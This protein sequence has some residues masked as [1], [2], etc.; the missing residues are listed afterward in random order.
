MSKFPKLLT[1]TAL[2]AVLATPAIA[3]KLGLGREA[4]PE[5]VAAWNHDIGPQGQGLPVGSGSVE[6][7]EMIFSDNCASCHGEFA[8]GAGNW[9]KLAGGEGSLA[10]KDPLKTV[11][12]YWPYLSTVYDY[13]RRSMPFGAAQTMSDN[14]VYA[15]TAYIL[16]S[17]YLVED[18][19]V[20][21]NEN[22]LDV[23]MPNAGGF[24][25]DDREAA[26]AHFWGE[27]CYEN[28]KESVEIT[29][30]AAVLDVTPQEE[31]G[32][33]VEAD[34]ATS[35]EMPA[36]VAEAAAEAEAP[37]EEAA[38]VV[39]AFDADL[40]AK[41]ENVF[42]KCKACHQVG[43]GAKNKTGPILNG[44]YMA[45]VAHIDGFKYSKDF[46]SAHDEGVIWDDAHLTEF[47]AKPKA[48]YKK[49]KM[50]FAGLKKDDD[51]VAVIEY[52]KSVSQ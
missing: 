14:D 32:D 49:T 9:P 22:F 10:D 52:L 15:I 1:A 20:L 47:L 6:D 45:P 33:T 28:C 36:Q 30:R 42:K 17:N 2:V 40:A 24:I 41:G 7:G 13:V 27:A 39:A 4:L 18:D 3:E 50:S 16:Y 38:A 44:V 34:S 46:A 25:I 12:S 8:E 51:I 48:V 23:E 29:K 35:E 19:F 21:S 5:E 31:T 26:E 37:V 43:E 11:G